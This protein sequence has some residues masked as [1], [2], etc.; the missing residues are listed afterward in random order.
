MPR[1]MPNGHLGGSDNVASDFAVAY[2]HQF[3][4]GISGTIALEDPKQATRPIFNG[5]TA[6]WRRETREP[7]GCG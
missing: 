6:R 4:N 5:T 2:T 7:A 1:T 3:G